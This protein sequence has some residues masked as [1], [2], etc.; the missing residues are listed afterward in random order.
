MIIT[1][2][3]NMHMHMWTHCNLLAVGGAHARK[4]MLCSVHTTSPLEKSR[5]V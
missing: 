2:Y 1:T 5:L 4:H 3:M